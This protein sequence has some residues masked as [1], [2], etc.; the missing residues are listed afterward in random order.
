MTCLHLFV[1]SW[2]VIE[3][4]RCMRRLQYSKLGIGATVGRL[5]FG[6]IRIAE[7]AFDGRAPLLQ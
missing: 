1:L 7:I 2:S 5:P 4:K 3:V 6:P